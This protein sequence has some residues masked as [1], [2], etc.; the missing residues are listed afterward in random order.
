MFFMHRIYHKK[1]ID[2]CKQFS[3]CFFFQI[4]IFASALSRLLCSL[5]R[6]LFFKYSK[7]KTKIKQMR[8]NSFGFGFFFSHR[9]IILY[10]CRLITWHNQP[11]TVNNQRFC[12]VCFHSDC[13][14]ILIFS[15]IWFVF[16]CLIFRMLVIWLQSSIRALPQYLRLY[17]HAFLLLLV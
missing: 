16:F 2:N 10:T 6:L 4:F 7:N 17:A 14:F 5:L 9:N 15:H 11:I 12:F 8:Y 13:F 3:I 1:S